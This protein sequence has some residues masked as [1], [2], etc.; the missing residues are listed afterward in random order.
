MWKQR[1]PQGLALYLGAVWGLVE[2]VSFLVARYR[3]TDNLVDM[4]GLGALLLFP[5]VVAWMLRQ[6]PDPDDLVDD[7]DVWVLGGNLLLAVGLVLLVFRGEAFGRATETVTVEGE[8]GALVQREVPRGDLLRAIAIA[9]L[10]RGDAQAPE[11]LGIAMAQMLQLDLSQNA[12]I[13]LVGNEASFATRE[14]DPGDLSVQ[15]RQAIARRANAHYFIDGTVSGTA[16]RVTVEIA[17][18]R[19]DPLQ[20]LVTLRST[21]LPLDDTVDALSPSLRDVLSLP[22]ERAAGSADG[23]VA[24]LLS[25]DAE[26]VAAMF[27]A[28]YLLS[29]ARDITGARGEIET[30]IGRDPKFAVAGL[31]LF[32]LGA[33]SGDTQ[34]MQ[35]GL[36]VAFDNRERFTEELRCVVRTIHASY[37]GQQDAAKRIARACVEQFPN[38]TQTRTYYAEFLR[39]IDDDIEGA[40][41]QYEAVLALG[42]AN[43]A[44]LL[45]IARLRQRAGDE[46]GALRAYTDY[47]ALKPDDPAVII[48]LV[49]L[50][51][52][53]G[54]RDLARE[55]LLDGI[56]RIDDAKT[57]VSALAS[58]NLREGR[59]DAALAAVASHATAE[60]PE[61]RQIYL[62][63]AEQVAEARGQLA[64]AM[65]L[66]DEGIAL[67]PPGTAALMQVMRALRFAET[68]HDGAGVAAFEPLLAQA[69]PA[70]DALAESGKAL[71]RLLFAL[72]V[73]DAD[74]LRRGREALLQMIP[75]Y[76]RRDL[77]F[78]EPL[79]AAREAQLAGKHAEALPRFAEAYRGHQRSGGE[80]TFGEMQLLR[81]WLTAAAAAA[82]REAGALPEQVLARMQ[83]G[84]P[85]SLLARARYRA[86]IGDSAA[87]DEL[88]TRA[89]DLWADA[90]AGYP[91][92]EEARALQRELA[93]RREG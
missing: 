71:M 2:V 65:A 78:L 26:A 28:E 58:M 88:L 37:Q 56:A 49:D 7:R 89:L 87:A 91:P 46:A 36:A 51:V 84:Y 83:P 30:A 34:A 64:A 1:I 43:D 63:V 76:G 40:I 72:R 27:R 17:V 18:Y 57:L 23:P 47:L 55:R 85:A 92:R 38:N 44:A 60:A 24:S 50:E 74:D 12:F 48:A 14:G 90:D 11:W 20:S 8:S 52:R 59:F 80:A 15:R 66:H 19:T 39:I 68:L 61:D 81:L 45:Q 67:A 53:R 21:G 29:T 75:Q 22:A 77:V 16:D 69:Y 93:A 73:G 82:D 33:S 32:Y 25:D 62:R 31:R 10:Q 79:I 6:R 41:A 9:P 70:N 54:D 35:R 13:Q 42:S 5:S 86:A 4:V 3:L